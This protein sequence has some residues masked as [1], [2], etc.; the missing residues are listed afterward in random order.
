MVRISDLVLPLDQVE[1][2]EESNVGREA[3]LL[4]EIAELGIPVPKGFV[5]TANAY[6]KY[7]LA[8]QEVPELVAN[9]IFRAYK[10]LDTPL[11]DANIV[12]SF[13]FSKK[14][15]KNVKGEAN[16]MQKIKTYWSIYFTDHDIDYPNFQPAILVQKNPESDQSGIMFT[17][18]SGYNDKTKI[19]IYEGDV[20]GNRYEISRHN[21]IILNRYIKK[22]NKQKLTD[23]QI[24]DLS[25][26]G[27]KLQKH[28]YFPQEV[29]FSIDKG[30]AYI[31]KTKPLTTFGAK[32]LTDTAAAHI[33]KKAI[34]I[35][36]VLLRGN[37]IYPGI[38]T[39]YI[40]IIRRPHDIHKLKA[41]DIA[42][43]TNTKNLMLSVVAKKARA[44]IIESRF[45]QL[46]QHSLQRSL[47]KP[48]IITMPFSNRALKEGLV[49]TV[50]GALGEMYI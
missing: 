30:R 23:K 15:F 42:V 26:W 22:G 44:V 24:I 17:V 39:G 21:S 18:D 5:V 28:Y 29:H 8:N 31:T 36:K 32:H 38:A 41:G 43:V 7:F 4:A 45:H 49:V 35:R 48:T 11:R 16:L 6:R 10:N 46:P 1:K 20:N 13:S 50:N 33:P 19:V 9:K 34:G 37:S 2:S 47:G 12:V 40:R 3:A 14:K 27:I 25:A